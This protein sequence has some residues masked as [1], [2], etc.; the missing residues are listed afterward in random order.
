MDVESDAPQTIPWFNRM[1]ASV[2]RRAAV[3]WVLYRNHG[4]PKL[5][6]LGQDADE[7][8]FQGPQEPQDDPGTF[9]SVCLS[10]NMRMEDVRD[11]IRAITEVDAR[12][13]RGLDFD[14]EDL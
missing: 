14:D 2:I 3:D 13:L 4:S 8:L 9:A 5:Q 10:L 12:H 11:R 1:W 6:R 7:W